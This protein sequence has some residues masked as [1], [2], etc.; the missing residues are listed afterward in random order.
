[1]KVDVYLRDGEG[2]QLQLLFL[3]EGQSEMPQPAMRK[4]WLKLFT[5]MDTDRPVGNLPVE[6]VVA[7][8]NRKGFSILRVESWSRD[9]SDITEG[10]LADLAEPDT[11]QD[12]WS[13][14]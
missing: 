3:P 11:W 6:N 5:S 4:R 7:D 12:K 1:M 10:E 13:L 9:W 2:L 8:V 14:G